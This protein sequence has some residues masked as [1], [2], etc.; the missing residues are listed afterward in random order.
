MDE[1]TAIQGFWAFLTGPGLPEV[2]L[3]VVVAAAGIIGL[4]VWVNRP[5]EADR[6]ADVAESLK[7]TCAALAEVA[8]AQATQTGR[9]DDLACHIR[10]MGVTLKSLIEQEAKRV[11]P[12]RAR[13]K[14]PRK[15]TAAA[16]SEAATCATAAL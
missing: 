14:S 8:A 11:S 16:G 9:L 10:D 5:R 2:K 13:A 1:A 7:A 4:R 6:A 3:A 12:R 15:R